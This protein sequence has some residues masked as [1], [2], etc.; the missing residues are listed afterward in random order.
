MLSTTY[1]PKCASFRSTACMARS[2]TGSRPGKRVAS[3]GRM[4]ALVRS[5]ENQPVDIVQMTVAHVSAGSQRARPALRKLGDRP[6]DDVEP[7]LAELRVDE[8]LDLLALRGVAAPA[9][10]ARQLSS[11]DDVE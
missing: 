11:R 9:G 4:S 2:S 10:L 7:L 6:V 5:L 1:S 8:A 3:N